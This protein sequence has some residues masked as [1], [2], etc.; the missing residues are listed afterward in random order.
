MRFFTPNFHPF[1]FSLQT[2][3]FDSRDRLDLK[4]KNEDHVSPREQQRKTKTTEKLDRL[5]QLT[6]KESPYDPVNSTKQTNQNNHG[7][8]KPKSKHKHQPQSILVNYSRNLP[9]H[10]TPCKSTSSLQTINTNLKDRSYK[11]S[12]IHRE[13]SN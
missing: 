13:Y 4:I 9:Q 11:P 12:L 5:H 7:V 1:P 6:T 8:N 3:I 2:T 10:K